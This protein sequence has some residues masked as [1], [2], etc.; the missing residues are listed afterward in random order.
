MEW[1][2]RVTQIHIE[3]SV[4]SVTGVTDDRGKPETTWPMDFSVN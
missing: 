4:T 2:A 1:A 3:G